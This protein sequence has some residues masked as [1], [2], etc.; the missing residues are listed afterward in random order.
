M[1]VKSEVE[2]EVEVG[3]VETLMAMRSLIACSWVRTGII[4]VDTNERK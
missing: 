4:D 2:S 1:K 3:L